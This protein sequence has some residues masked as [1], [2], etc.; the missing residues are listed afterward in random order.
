MEQKSGMK[1]EES[2][3]QQRRSLPCTQICF[4]NYTN[5]RLNTVANSFIGLSIGF[6]KKNLILKIV[7]TSPR[8]SHYSEQE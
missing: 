6:R 5:S 8:H 2:I 3:N 4:F 1:E 7:T